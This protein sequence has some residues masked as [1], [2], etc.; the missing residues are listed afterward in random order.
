LTSRGSELSV[1]QMLIPYQI[2]VVEDHEC[3][4]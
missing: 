3:E 4:L 2:D 1:P